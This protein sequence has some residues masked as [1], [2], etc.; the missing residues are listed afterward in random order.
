MKNRVFYEEVTSGFGVSEL[1]YETH[2]DD[3]LYHYHE[4]NRLCKWSHDRRPQKILAWLQGKA[5][6]YGADETALEILKSAG[7]F[8]EREE[9]TNQ[10]RFQ[11]LV[12]EAARIIQAKIDEHV[13]KEMESG[14]KFRQSKRGPGKMAEILDQELEEIIIRLG[15]E[16][17]FTNIINYIE[18]QSERFHEVWQEID[19]YNKEVHFKDPNQNQY[20][21]KRTFKAIQHRITKIKKKLSNPP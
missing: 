20:E 7:Q 15:S 6:E 16:A 3:A 8:V 14:K 13:P 1:P 18:E 21:D 9:I 17:T 12:R 10:T 19:R 2:P 5:S 11:E 4:G